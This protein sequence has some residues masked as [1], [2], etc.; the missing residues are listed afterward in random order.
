MKK[1]IANGI[2]LGLALTGLI[3]LPAS[4]TDGPRPAGSKGGIAALVGPVEPVPA[5]APHRGT[6]DPKVKRA[7]QIMAKFGIPGGPVDGYSGAQTVQGLCA[8]RRMTGQTPTRGGLDHQIYLK[9]VE[10]DAKY[11][12]I[13]QF[14]A[15]SFQGKV[16]YVHV[17]MT[18][19]TAFYV[20][21]K[22][23]QRVLR[24]STGMRGHDTPSGYYNLGSTL[25]GW[26]RSTLY[27]ESC[28]KQTTGEFAYLRNFGN[29]YNSRQ[30][31]G[32]IYL[33]G[34]TSVPTYPASHGCI[35]VSV[36]DADW[37]YHKVA[38]M[39]IFI[40]GKYV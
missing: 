23:Y 37:M 39:P 24:V 40:T 12:S 26:W 6:P 10:F 13:G 22:T 15:S 7:Q 29:M 32:A 28:R 20:K 5:E 18:C 14:P 9:L 31:I 3:A 11:S 4:A 34:S 8:F 25:K 1:T 27:P 30:V 35:R 19:Q 21:D 16:T 2:G 33:H 17:Q 36:T 38:N